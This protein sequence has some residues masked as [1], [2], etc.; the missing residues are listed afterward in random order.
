MEQ[1]NTNMQSSYTN[2]HEVLLRIELGIN[3]L[4]VLTNFI[5]NEDSIELLRLEEVSD[6]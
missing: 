4:R 3:L 1:E 2:K 6:F 5:E